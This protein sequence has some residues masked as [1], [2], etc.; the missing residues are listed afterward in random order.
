M[1]LG[2]FGVAIIAGLAVDN[3]ADNILSRALISMFVCNVVGFMV[4]ILAERTLS[5]AIGA[6]AKAQ[7]LHE[8]PADGSL[9]AQAASN[10][11]RAAA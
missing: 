5:E 4:G 1:G 11:S 6:Y 2:A 3:P 9:A 7:S 8:Q 10:P